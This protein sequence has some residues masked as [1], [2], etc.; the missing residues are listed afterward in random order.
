MNQYFLFIFF[1]S[2]SLLTSCSG[3]HIK[4]N[5]NPLKRYNIKTVYLPGLINRSSLPSLD[6]YFNREFAALLARFP[7][8][9]VNNYRDEK[10]DAV[11]IG[12]I[13]SP[14]SYFQTVHPAQMVELS[15]D[16]AHPHQ[17][18]PSLLLRNNIKVPITNIINLSLELYLVKGPSKKMIELIE[19]E[20]RHSPLLKSPKVIFHTIIP[21]RKLYGLV[22]PRRMILAPGNELLYDNNAAGPLGFARNHQTMHQT[23]QKMAEESARIFE[24]TMLNAF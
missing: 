6:S 3:Y 13:D 15:G 12:I 23:L 16:S 7:Q 22:Y 4:E 21:L 11:L 5:S 20:G 2:I 1:I 9:N 10:S 17:F 19:K 24:E 14:P 8:L 18:Y